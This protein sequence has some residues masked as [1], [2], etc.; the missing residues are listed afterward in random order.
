M[1]TPY[2]F[3]IFALLFITSISINSIYVQAHSGKKD[4][5]KIDYCYDGDTCTSS[6]GEKIRLACIDA[7]EL[8]GSR[9]NPEKAKA[10]RD[11]LSRLISGKQIRIHRITKDRYGRTVG[12]L[13]AGELN[14]QEQMVRDGFAKIYEKYAFQCEWSK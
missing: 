1:S 2:K 5:I 8:K 6:K 13:F 9:A 11:Y 4:N 14:I 3:L 12:E 7:P 10:A